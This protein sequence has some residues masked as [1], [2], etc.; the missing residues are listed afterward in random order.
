MAGTSSPLTDGYY[1]VTGNWYKLL[2]VKGASAVIKGTTFGD[3]EVDVK[4]GDFGDADKEICE[5]TGQ[6]RFH[7]ELSFSVHEQVFKEL[8]VITEKGMKIT[9]KSMMS[10]SR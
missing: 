5:T 1:K 9:T 10:S 3:V 7:L 6:T 4:Y 8:G 2:L